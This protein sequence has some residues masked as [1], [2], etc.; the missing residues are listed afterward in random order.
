[1]AYDDPAVIS[2]NHY[3]PLKYG[4]E[5]QQQHLDQMQ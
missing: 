3:T 4:L 5:E 2:N 1:M